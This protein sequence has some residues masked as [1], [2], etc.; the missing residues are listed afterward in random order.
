MNITFKIRGEAILNDLILK[1]PCLSLYQKDDLSSEATDFVRSL[2]S[3]IPERRLTV[4]QAMQ[5]PFFS[6]VDWDR[7]S[8]KTWRHPPYI[9]K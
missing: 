5:H 1:S 8:T 7:V 6:G 3:R 2:L 4:E 9:P